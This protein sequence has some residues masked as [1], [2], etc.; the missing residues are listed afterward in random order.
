MASEPGDKATRPTAAKSA[1]SAREGLPKETIVL[2]D[3]ALPDY[4][5]KKMLEDRIRYVKAELDS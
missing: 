5:R 1:P 4:E 2:D 3:D